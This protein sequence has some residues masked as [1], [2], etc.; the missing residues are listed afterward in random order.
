MENDDFLPCCDTAEDLQAIDESFSRQIACLFETLK[1]LEDRERFSNGF[2]K[3]INITIN[4]PT[5]TVWEHCIHHRYLCWRVY[6][7]WRENLPMLF[8]VKTLSF[9]ENGNG[10]KF[11]DAAD[12]TPFKLDLRVMLDLSARLLCLESLRCELIN[13]AWTVTTTLK[14]SDTILNTGMGLVAIHAWNLAK[15]FRKIIPLYPRH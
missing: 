5:R 3:N 4:T 8:S 10:H 15:L 12:L 13:E 11:C 6:L 2:I 14:L 7:L 1:A 9:K